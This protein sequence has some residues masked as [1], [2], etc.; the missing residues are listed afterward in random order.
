MTC[1]ECEF[2]KR[3][4]FP[5]AISE[6]F[7]CDEAILL[8]GLRIDSEITPSDLRKRFAD[9]MRPNS[10]IGEGEILDRARDV[11]VPEER[12]EVAV[13]Q[14]AAIERKANALDRQERE[15]IEGGGEIEESQGIP[16]AQVESAN[17]APPEWG[18][19][20]GGR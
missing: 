9:S 14:A 11:G 13:R 20:F 7:G 6:P 12:I 15:A 16:P 2:W 4:C 1:Q 19:L 8:P 10:E 5:A 3:S 17:P 18:P